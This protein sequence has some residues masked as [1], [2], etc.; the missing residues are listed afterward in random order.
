ML[1]IKNLLVKTK[2]RQ[3]LNGVSFAIKKG[4]VH[5]IMGPNGSGK[6]TLA[7]ILM[8]NP[9]YEIIGGSIIFDKKNI[10]NLDAQKRAV[11]GMFMAFQYPREIA[12][13]Q[14]DRFLY[15]CYGSVMKAREK[16][17]EN[18]SVFDFN[19]RLEVQA[20]ALKMNPAFLQRSLNVGFSGG[21]KKKAEMLQLAILEP[22]FVILDE[23]DSGLDVDALKIVGK[24]V[25]DYKDKNNSILIITHYNRVLD[26]IRPDK[27]HIM[28]DGKIVKSGGKELIKKI[29]KEGF[30]KFI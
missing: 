6:S 17:K 21:E 4:E 8:G 23:T 7:N 3:I 19:K 29:E 26:Y 27:V 30:G 18:L 25:N 11:L 14:L 16:T 5:V 15:M 2:N 28:V 22:K 24:A 1:E 10:K 12:G 9:N 20:K 13:V